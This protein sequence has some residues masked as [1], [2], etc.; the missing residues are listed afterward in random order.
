MR[1][2]NAEDG[3]DVAQGF[4]DERACAVVAGLPVGVGEVGEVVVLLDPGGVLEEEKV[5]GEAF[6]EDDDGRYG[7]GGDERVYVG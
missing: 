4:G 6:L 2:V 5:A 1:V 7:F 3:C